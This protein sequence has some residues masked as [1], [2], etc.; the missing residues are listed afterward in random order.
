MSDVQNVNWTIKL[1]IYHSSFL[2]NFSLPERRHKWS[3]KHTISAASVLVRQSKLLKST[4]LPLHFTNL[5]SSVSIYILYSTN[6]LLLRDSL[7]GR[8]IYAPYSLLSLVPDY[9][10]CT[11][12]KSMEYLGYCV[13]NEGWA[14]Y[15]V[16]WQYPV[17]F[18]CIPPDFIVENCPGYA[19]TKT[20]WQYWRVQS[21]SSFNVLSLNLDT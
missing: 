4:L 21:Y 19:V 14:E 9:L 20:I 1:V 18:E 16:N 3:S 13:V 12:Y 11:W 7:R 10:T 15:P 5:F 17:R 8:S 6:I 2:F